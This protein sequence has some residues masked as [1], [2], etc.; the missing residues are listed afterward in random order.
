[1]P[2]RQLKTP[3][4]S[5][6]KEMG[7]VTGKER[8]WDA[9]K[10]DA[11]GTDTARRGDASNSDTNRTDS[12]HDRR[13]QPGTHTGAKCESRPTCHARATAQNS[14]KEL[15]QGDGTRVRVTRT[16]QEKKGDGMR[17]RV[18]RMGQTQQGEVMRRIV[19]RTEQ[20]HRTTVDDSQAPIQALS[21][22]VAQHAMPE[23]QL[24]TPVRS[25]GKEMG[26]V[27]GKERRWDAC[28]SDANGT[29]TA[30]R[31]D[32]SNSDTNR[33][34][35]SHDRR[36]QPGTHTGAKCESRPTCHARATAQ[37]SRKE[38]RQKDGTRVR[39]TRTG[40]EKK[41]DG[42]RARVTRM[43]QT[44]QGEVMRRIVIRT[45]QIHRTTVDDSQAPIKALSARVAHH[46]MPERQLKTP[47]RS[48]GEEMGRVQE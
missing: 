29:D 28:K 27:T 14:R 32:A 12:S 48:Y 3:V 45:E 11:N 39:V 7:R 20:I 15:R 43:G 23:R 1:M 18:T 10:S 4:R 24:K 5:Y 16:G 44:Q 42:M 37:N 47:V 38:L 30:R 2:E 25:Y 31:G 41:G 26:R 46:A 35:S 40:Q 13:R 21:A 19:I 22:R 33:T 8:R 17:A 36:R 34:D 6:G 9:C